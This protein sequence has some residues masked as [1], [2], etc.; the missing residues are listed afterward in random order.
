MDMVDMKMTAEQRK[1]YCGP[2]EPSMGRPEYPYGLSISLDDAGI[3]KLGL[4]ALPA[5][6][7]EMIL[8]AR[9][10]VTDVRQHQDQE[11]VDRGMSLQIT[12]MALDAAPPEKST[13]EALY[14]KGA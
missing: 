4:V 14:A 11:G 6:G 1:E 9:V 3:G 2:C 10:T 13:A 5:A 7:Q 12:K 8:H